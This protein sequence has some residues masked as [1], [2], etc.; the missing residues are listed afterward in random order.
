MDI[1]VVIIGAGAA[2]IAAA[3]RLRGAG[4]TVLLIEAMGRI[5]G[6]AHTVLADGL[7]VDLG[8]GWLHSAERNPLV[9]IAESSGVGIDRTPAAWRKQLRNL[10]FPLADQ[11][12][13]EK[14]Y[15]ELDAGLRAGPADDVAGNAITQD[16]PW[17][18][19]LD[20]LSGALNGAELDH[21]SARDYLA[22]DDAASD[23]DWRLP[24]GYGALIA[25]AAADLP[26]RLGVAAT[27]ID[28]GGRRIAVETSAGT[29]MAD[30][31]IIAVPT[32][33]LARG[34]IRFSPRVDDHLHAAACLPLGRVDKLFLAIDRPDAI[35]AES[36]ML[37]DPR[38]ALTGSYYLRPF[39]R[40]LIECFFGGIAARA[41]E[42]VGDAGRAAFTI[43]ELG[44]LLGSDFARGLHPVAGSW[45]HAEPTIGGAYSHARPGESAQRA[46]LARPLSERL[47]FA[48]EACSREDYSTV[49]GAWASGIAA[50]AT[51]E[52]F[53]SQAA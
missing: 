25:G 38:A 19:Y 7:P 31:A 30:A 48:G 9:A 13:A 27:A 41:M 4:R 10:A 51:V 29:I 8:A 53:L 32:D 5:G 20:M 15:A 50:A 42:K 17:R 14:A 45:W 2:G 46:V 35:P 52:R 1:E 28:D 39:G 12:A 40:P 34:D 3:R 26:L 11:H 6:R 24:S 18:G 49:H 22:Y 16:H 47:A 36:H 43:D 23:T 44:R 33:I 21:V 37:G